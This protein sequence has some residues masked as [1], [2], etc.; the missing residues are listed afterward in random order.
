MENKI[1]LLDKDKNPLK[2]ITIER[3]PKLNLF[4][5]LSKVNV[6]KSGVKIYELT[7]ENKLE[8]K[9]IIFKFGKLSYLNLIWDLNNKNIF[10]FLSN[11][12]SN[13]KKNLSNQSTVLYAVDIQKESLVAE[14]FKFPKKNINR[15]SMSC[16]PNKTILA[17]YSKDSEIIILDAN[18]KTIIET[19]SRDDSRIINDCIFSPFDENLLLF[20]NENGNIYLYD[21]RNI[22]EPLKN[23]CP[24]EKG[25][26]SLSWH[27]TD[28]NLF[29]SGSLDNYIKIWNIDNEFDSKINFKTPKR[30][31]KVRFLKSNPKYIMCSYQTNNYNIDLWN[32]NFR[33]IPEYQFSGHSSDIIGFDNDVEG[34]RLISCDR[35]GTII[36]NEMNKGERTLDNITTN[37][38]IFN[39]FNEIYY[40]HDDKLPEENFVKLNNN[41]EGM[42]NKENPI[43]QSKFS[44]EIE[45]YNKENE[46]IKKV[47]MLNFN[48]PEIGLKNKKIEKEDK[49]IFLKNDCYLNIN[50]ELRQ[51]Y[52][53]NKDQIHSLFR[54]YIYYI[55]EKETLYKRKRFCSTSGLY[56]LESSEEIVSVEIN[57]DDLDF[58]EKLIRGISSN[59]DYAKNTLNNYNHISIWNTLL[60]LSNQQTFRLLYD[61]YSG[62]KIEKKFK[63]KKRKNNRKN[64]NSDEDKNL[65]DFDDYN[66]SLSPSGIN[67]MTKLFIKE[68]SRI[69]EFLID[70]YGDIYLATIICYLFKPILF[71]DNIL[72]MRILRLIKQCVNNLRKYQLYVDANHLIKY[73]PMENK[74]V[75]KKNEYRF[76]FSCSNCNWVLKDGKCICKKE[77]LGEE[78]NLKALGLLIWCSG[79][80]HRFHINHI[81][82]IPILYNCKACGH[83]CISF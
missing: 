5:V 37:T 8:E 48:H 57:V 24:E 21:I 52:I 2:P 17:C 80:G 26:M 42:D 54:S 72:K 10:H 3:N 75:E 39:D 35:K 78:H 76:T 1:Q 20:S 62:G 19:I 40:Y 68:L 66:L 55:E 23:F 45:N 59:L 49:I 47:S 43:I 56:K 82:E 77:L 70:T 31:S 51:Y 83:R 4:G 65:Y 14:E 46:M 73:G 74:E 28:P 60:Y 61:K 41:N 11:P 18:N 63:K 81:N 38:I 16:N 36:I 29:C 34:K 15:L 6:S 69:M 9:K 67:L 22:K 53:F 32:L 71:Q 25:I 7:E 58:S 79:C 12:N 27:P 44:E 50:S 30:I 13:N 33:D 64:K